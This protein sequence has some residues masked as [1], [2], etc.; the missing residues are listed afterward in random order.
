MASGHGASPFGLNSEGLKRRG[1][2]KQA[3]LAIR[4]AYKE[5]YRK[6]LSVED[7]LI[8]VDEIAGEFEQVK[9]FAEFIRES[10]RGIIR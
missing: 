5:I 8:G 3:I 10:N 6:G 4:R 1:F 7:A 2:E 9:I